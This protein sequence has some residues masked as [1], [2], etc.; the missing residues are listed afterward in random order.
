MRER[1]SL[2]ESHIE[3]HEKQKK[4]L[5]HDFDEFKDEC[6][7]HETQLQSE[8]NHRISV[9]SKELLNYQKEFES[10]IKNF[11]ALVQAFELEKTEAIAD[12][13]RIHQ[14]EI[15]DILK[16]QMSKSSD[17]EQK[18]A[19]EL[20]LLKTKHIAELQQATSN[21]DKLKIEK[22]QLELDY[23]E[24]FKKSKTLYEN[25]LELLRQSQNDQSSE[26]QKV[27]QDKIDRLTKDFQF[28]QAQF[29]HRIDGLVNDL[30]VSEDTINQLKSNLDILTTQKSDATEEL[31]NLRAQ[32][33]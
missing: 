5:L 11:E 12:L 22:E 18:L 10:K 1:I 6:A 24:K 25:E 14:K 8:H 7:N 27:L 15:D 23:E 13:K 4:K 19:D 30:S 26:K 17:N 32:V 2:L 31:A 33:K 9:V 29:R 28:Q 3:E 21:Y 16:T 20:E